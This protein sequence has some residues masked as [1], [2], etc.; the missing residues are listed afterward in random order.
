MNFTVIDSVEVTIVSA[1]S[2][3][4]PSPLVPDRP[5]DYDPDL[6]WDEANSVWTPTARGGGRYKQQLVAVGKDGEI[7]YGDVG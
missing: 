1:P 7:Y 6:G 5:P 2:Y 3:L 4:I